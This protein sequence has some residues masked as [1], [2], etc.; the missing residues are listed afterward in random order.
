MKCV[1]LIAQRGQESLIIS[2]RVTEYKYDC[3]LS[4]QSGSLST[5]VLPSTILVAYSD[6]LMYCIYCIGILIWQINCFIINLSRDLTHTGSEYTDINKDLYKK[7][8]H[9]I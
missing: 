8:V 5:F 4:M 6:C 1:Y 7:I 3:P 2:L 9:F